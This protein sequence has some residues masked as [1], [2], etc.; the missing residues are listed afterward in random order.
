MAKWRSLDLSRDKNVTE[1]RGGRNLRRA[2]GGKG[3]GSS[4]VL[5]SGTNGRVCCQN[6]NKQQQTTTNMK[7]SKHTTMKNTEQKT[8]QTNMQNTEKTN[9][10]NTNRTTMKRREPK[11]QGRVQEVG[12]AAV[13]AVDGCTLTGEKGNKRAERA[14]GIK[15]SPEML[16]GCFPNA[17]TLR[18]AFR[19]LVMRAENARGYVTEDDV[20][21]ALSPDECRREELGQLL[22]QLHTCGI[23][24]TEEIQGAV[25]DTA[26]SIE[27]ESADQYARGR[28]ERVC[29]IY[30]DTGNRISAADPDEEEGDVCDEELEE[31]EATE[32]ESRDA[33]R[34]GAGRETDA[35]DMLR[36]Y[37]RKIGK[38]KLLTRQEEVQLGCRISQA[39][40]VLRGELQRIGV[41]WTYYGELAEKLLQ[42]QGRYEQVVA[43]QKGK[44]R[45]EYSQMLRNI[46]DKLRKYDH[47]A[48]IVY[49]NLR[50]E[51]RRGRGCEVVRLELRA[52]NRKL[53]ELCKALRYRE[54]VNRWVVE[55]LREIRERILTLQETP[56]DRVSR[57]A[58]SDIE[59]Q[60]R[61]PV[62]DFLKRYENIRAA[63]NELVNARKE[64][65]EANLRLVV[66]QAKKFIGRGLDFEDLIQEGNKGLMKAVEK[67]EHKR[68]YKFSTYATWW[69]IQ[70]ITRAIADCG[71]TIRVP[72]HA[73]ESYNKLM[74]VKTILTQKF[75]REATPKEIAEH[76]GVTE[77]HVQDI[78]QAFVP[79]VSI[80]TPLGSEPN[81]SSLET[82]LEDPGAVN[83]STAVDYN[84]LHEK[85]QLLLSILDKRQRTVI[86]LRF[87][88]L[89][90]QPMTLEEV[91]GLFNVTRERIRQIEKAAL[92]KLRH[93]AH[94]ELCAALR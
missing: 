92:K 6:N 89:D 29:S 43:E 73:K 68:G 75:G 69:I 14:I 49:R 35:D 23:K 84:M 88:L 46:L 65:A 40:D 63:Q 31:I 70:T 27:Q 67:F 4:E 54:N 32:E 82:V 78:F 38:K 51:R 22:K 87:G 9:N 91:G 3:A 17:P 94:R 10:Q 80:Y 62:G 13:G 93:P 1:D 66:S 56:N 81:G 60:L 36:G 33:G 57:D 19:K 55:R 7:K 45:A 53:T 83:P 64:L 79:T 47:D 5:E 48:D 20:L 44:T 25:R 77:K 2:G 90:D 39:R 85:I 12:T 34:R 42:G 18:D 24:V 11:R 16:Q 50:R 28:S 52:I 86:I 76:C 58:L 61:M 30:G 8:E 74:R 37:F 26:D 71:R 59:M 15:V 21:D 72:V 41:V